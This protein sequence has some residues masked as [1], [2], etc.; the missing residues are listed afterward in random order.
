MMLNAFGSFPQ[1]AACQAFHVSCT[2]WLHETGPFVDW[3]QVTFIWSEMQDM[4]F[5]RKASLVKQ[6]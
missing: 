5:Q 3:W 6:K 2:V 1:Y 4:F